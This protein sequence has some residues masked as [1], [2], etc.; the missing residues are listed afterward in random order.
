MV[1]QKPNSEDIRK[2]QSEATQLV[3]QRFL[4]GTIG[5]TA[6]GVITTWIIP[7]EVPHLGDEIGRFRYLTSI[8]LL[9]VLFSLFFLMHKLREMLRTI[10][11]YLVETGSSGWEVD[12]KRFKGKPC[13]SYTRAQTWLFL[14]LGMLS[15]GVPF[16]IAFAYNLKFE[17][18]GGALAL[19]GVGIVYVTLLYGMGFADWFNNEPQ[20]ERRWKDLN[21][22]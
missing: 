12:W 21:Q 5:V 9:V 3:N 16:I 6:F 20:I 14:V 19:M 22:P 11:A 1:L 10:S 18:I 4:L 7:K 15:I 13:A 8:V 17:P 2:L